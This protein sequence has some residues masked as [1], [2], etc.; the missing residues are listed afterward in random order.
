M[1]VGVFGTWR[2]Q[3]GDELYS[4]AHEVGYLVTQKGFQIVTGG[5]SGVMEAACRGSVEAGGKPIGVTCPEIDALLPANEWVYDEIKSQN[6]AERTY[7][8]MELC[9]V[10]IFFSGRTGTVCELAMA[11]ELRSKGLLKQPIILMGNFWESFFH[12]LSSSNSKLDYSL[13]S[14]RVEVYKVASSPNEALL[15]ITQ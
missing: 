9:D 8:C 13:D 3:P 1:R 6:I 4:F 2:A 12:W 5:Y 10:T 15:L 11:A 7:R 14:E